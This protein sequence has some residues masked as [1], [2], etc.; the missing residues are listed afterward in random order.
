MPSSPSLSPLPARTTRPRA[1]SGGLHSLEAASDAMKSGANDIHHA[2]DAGFKFLFG[3]LKEKRAASSPTGSPVTST[4]RTL[5]DARKLVS[6]EEESPEDAES[7]N[8]DLPE[9]RYDGQP[10]GLEAQKLQG[11]AMAE[12]ALRLIN[13]SLRER[14]VDSSKSPGSLGSK[15]TAPEKPPLTKQ[16]NLPGQPGYNPVDSFRN[17]G[18]A[19]NPFRGFTGM[20]MSRSF[21]RVASTGSATG[22]QSLDSNSLAPPNSP[23]PPKFPL[24]PSP[25]V[26]EV[27]AEEPQSS[28]ETVFDWNGVAPPMQRFVKCSDAR[29]LN[30]FEVELLLRDYQR[31][32]GALGAATVTR[33]LSP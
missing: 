22:V 33:S 14:S 16:T 11:F 23:A 32:A 31:L 1:F 2:L 20:G 4:P 8:E 10:K 29:E 5:E 15:A 26:R 21:G 17:I 18:N 3:R 7:M 9:I 25:T 27:V 13:G 28:Q 6:Q 30:F 24:V 19:L 12:E